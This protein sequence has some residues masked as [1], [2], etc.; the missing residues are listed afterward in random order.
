MDRSMRK[1]ID[2]QGRSSL[3][4]RNGLSK[5]R[6]LAIAAAGNRLAGHRHTLWIA[7][8]LFGLLFAAS[9]AKAACTYALSSTSQAYSYVATN[10][11]V[12]VTT[13]SGCTWTVSNTNA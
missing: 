6:D 11:T 2:K 5:N 13:G 1:D 12:T 9:H 10:G 3:S 4:Q 7:V 8:A